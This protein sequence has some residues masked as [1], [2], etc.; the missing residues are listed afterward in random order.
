[1]V[2]EKASMTTVQRGRIVA[3][4]CVDIAL[5]SVCIRVLRIRH[6]RTHAAEIGNAVR[7]RAGNQSVCQTQI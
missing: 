4:V 2:G 3:I 6:A 5:L 7:T 1:M